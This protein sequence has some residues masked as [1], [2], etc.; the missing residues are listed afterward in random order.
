MSASESTSGPPASGGTGGCS[1]GPGGRA[2]R[3]RPDCVSDGI[4]MALAAER[5]AGGGGMGSRASSMGSGGPAGAEPSVGAV[6]AGITAAAARLDGDADDWAPRSGSR[7]AEV[8]TRPRFL[9]WW[10]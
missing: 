8:G 4:D 1:G 6:D 7:L 5:R 9:T 10:L 3:W 2:G